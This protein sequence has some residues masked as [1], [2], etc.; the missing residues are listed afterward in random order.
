MQAIAQI[1]IQEGLGGGLDKHGLPMVI[2]PGLI[3]AITN[4]VPHLPISA[5]S[6]LPAKP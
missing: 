6:A 1:K 2:S 4:L 3:D 5:L